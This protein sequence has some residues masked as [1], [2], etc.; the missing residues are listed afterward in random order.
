MFGYHPDPEGHHYTRWLHAFRAPNVAP[1][2]LRPSACKVLDQGRSSGCVGHGT[3]TGVFTAA[4]VAGA[5]LGFIPSPAGIYVNAVALERGD[6]LRGPL[7]DQGSMPSQAAAAL[8][9]FGVRPMQPQ[10]A[11]TDVHPVNGE[12]PE[13]NLDDLEQEGEHCYVGWYEI[14]NADEARIA[15]AAGAP[16]GIGTYVDSAFT[17]WDPS[18]PPL[19]YMNQSDPDGGGHWT[20]LL[21]FDASRFFLRNSWGPGWGDAGDCY[22]T[23]DFVNQADQLIA[24]GYKRIGGPK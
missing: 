9:I 11:L 4:A 14:G 1:R 17:R 10:S 20:V 21:G 7:L 22:V 13:P 5:P 2:D 3:A 16:V 15:L 6:P 23:D 8:S 19:G 24:F 18:K 12:L